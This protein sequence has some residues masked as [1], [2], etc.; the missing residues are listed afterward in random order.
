MTNGHPTQEIDIV[1]DGPPG[2]ISP[3]FIETET[4]EGVGV[5]LGKWVKRADG[6]WVLRIVVDATCVN[7]SDRE[8][9]EEVKPNPYIYDPEQNH[10]ADIEELSSSE[11]YEAGVSAG[12]G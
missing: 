6:H 3:S 5:S 7:R 11:A 10:G 1:F 9:P 12:L 4:P 2:P 8:D